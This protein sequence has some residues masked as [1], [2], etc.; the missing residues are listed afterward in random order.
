MR[1]SPGR[2][3]PAARRLHS[4]LRLAKFNATNG[5]VSIAGNLALMRLLVGEVKFNYVASNVIAIVVCSLVNFLLSDRFVF[6][7]DVIQPR[8]LPRGRESRGIT[9]LNSS[10]FYYPERSEGSAARG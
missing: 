1:D 4:L 10:E 7:A 3:R 2:D 8:S 9:P 6:E 5:A